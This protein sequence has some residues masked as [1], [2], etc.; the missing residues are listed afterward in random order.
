MR[1]KAYND[2][3]SVGYW[4]ELGGVEVKRIEYGI[5]D[6]ICC[7]SGTFAGKR[8]GHRVKVNYGDRCYIKLYGRRLYM[9]ECIRC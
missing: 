3:P 9:D 6:Y 7:V 8:Q 4:S 1:Y 5:D 2:L